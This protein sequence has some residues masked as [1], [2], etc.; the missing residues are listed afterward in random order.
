ME[1]RNC[2]GFIDVVISG[3][4]ELK[5]EIEMMADISESAFD[6]RNVVIPRS[7]LRRTQFLAENLEAAQ[8]R[9][10]EL[11][12]HIRAY[13]KIVLTEEQKSQLDEELNQANQW[14]AKH[15]GQ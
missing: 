7:E 11:E 1:I 3:S 8:R 9:G 4:E 13:R 12:M 5:S 2:Y 6:S 15:Y 14:L 10:T